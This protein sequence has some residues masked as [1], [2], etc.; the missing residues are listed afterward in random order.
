[1]KGEFYYKKKGHQGKRRKKRGGVTVAG[2][3]GRTQSCRAV[4][5]GR[6][7]RRQFKCTKPFWGAGIREKE[8]FSRTDGVKRG[9]KFGGAFPRKV[10]CTKKAAR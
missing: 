7:V 5:R 1:L 10:N 4:Q 9:E 8:F 2:Q 3:G 6:G